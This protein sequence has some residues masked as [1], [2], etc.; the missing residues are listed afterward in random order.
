MFK[1]ENLCH[2]FQANQEKAILKIYSRTPYDITV[3][4]G[5]FW[6][7]RRKELYGIVC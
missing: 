3:N 1:R 5:P 6:Q 7:S 2:F 4:I